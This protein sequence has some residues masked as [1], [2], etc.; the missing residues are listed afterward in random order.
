MF[1]MIAVRYFER[2]GVRDKK[3]KRDLA[4]EICDMFNDGEK[5]ALMLA[6]RAIE[7]AERDRI[8]QQE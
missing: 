8:A 6:N 7:K 4:S 2:Q 5:R 1:W 3:L